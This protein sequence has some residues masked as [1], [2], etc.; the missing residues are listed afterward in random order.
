MNDEASLARNRRP[1]HLLRPAP[2]LHRRRCDR[3]R[4]GD[5]VLPQQPVQVGGRPARDQRIHPDSRLAPFNGEG[6]GQ[7]DQ[8][9]FRGAVGADHRRR[10]DTSHRGHIDH[11]ALAAL[12][13]MVRERVTDVDRRAEVQL[14]QLVPARQPDVLKRHHEVRT[15]RVVDHDVDLTE[16]IDSGSRRVGDR[17]VAR[18]VGR[19]NARLPADGVNGLRRLGQPVRAA[20]DQGDIGTCLGECH[21]D[22]P[23]DSP[24]R[25]GHVG[26][27]AS[28]IK[29]AHRQSFQSVGNGQAAGFT[30]RTISLS[31][32]RTC[33]SPTHRCFASGTPMTSA[34]GTTANLRRASAGCR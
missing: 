19:D 5:F 27:L 16:L 9:G 18:H 21:G 12:E 7:R 1:G 23:P 15:A 8:S 25:T 10:R 11:R 29:E 20:R 24:G 33:R 32:T 14:D 34:C 4:S 30:R 2:P 22:N 6:P 13:Q 26:V 3:G 31:T 17:I 28:E